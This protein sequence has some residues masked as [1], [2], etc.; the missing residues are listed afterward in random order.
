MKTTNQ[1]KNPFATYEK[2]V[3]MATTKVV[4]AYKSAI[5]QAF[6]NKEV[7][8]MWLKSDHAKA[9]LKDSSHTL[10]NLYG[11]IRNATKLNSLPELKA[12]GV[13]PLKVELNELGKAQGV[14]KGRAPRTEKAEKTAPMVKLASDNSKHGDIVKAIMAGIHELNLAE[15]TRI[16]NA[17]TVEIQRKRKLAA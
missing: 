13:N 11:M 8:V 4:E 5:S 15:L 10:F 6:A 7:T 16:Q 1:Q 3:L 14:I 12:A 17:L 2:T 9:I